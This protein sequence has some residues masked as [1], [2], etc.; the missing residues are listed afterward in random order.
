MTIPVTTRSGQHLAVYGLGVSGLSAAHALAAGSARVTA[1][2]DQESARLRAANDGISLGDISDAL[3]RRNVSALVLGPGIPLNH[4]K[5]H[6][7]VERA[8]ETGIA[9]IGDIELLAETCPEAVLIGVTGT[10]GKSTTATLIHH[11]LREAG[12]PSQIGGNFGPPALGLR[13][14]EPG[15]SMVL[16][17]SSF[18]LDLT[19][20]AS[21]DIAVLLNLTP[22]HLDRHGS[23]ES[24]I[25]A[26]KRIFRTN[27]GGNPGLAIVGVDDEPGREIFEELKR[28]G[29]WNLRGVSVEHE[30]TD[31]ISVLD[32]RLRDGELGCDLRGA[33]ALQGPHNWQNA[34]AA[35]AVARARGTPPEVIQAAFSTFAGLPHRMELVFRIGDTRYVNDSKAT[36]GEAAARA[37]A[38]FH[39]IYWIAGGVAKKEGLTPTFPWL[40]H[41]HRAYLIG[42]AAPDFARQLAGRVE[43]S[44]STDLPTALRTARNQAESESTPS[45][46]IL[47]SP[48][49]ASFDQYPNFEARGDH[50]RELVL[51]MFREQT[52]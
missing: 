39:N 8:R 48:A 31:G 33:P 25:A 16:E 14:P 4:P 50:F 1:W 21:F 36:N 26:K 52:S 18:Q 51:S 28:S 35:W 10:N 34:A 7:V 49:C 19:H 38:S 30:V 13:Q 11:I 17:L 41:V 15:E 2:D 5:P 32:G 12:E 24:Y 23:M 6:P 46:V 27:S 42:E 40:D 22:D 44:V 20:R 47:L 43:V 29:H 9:I 45:P 3:D 37:I